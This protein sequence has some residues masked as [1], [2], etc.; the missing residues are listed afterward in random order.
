MITELKLHKLYS[1]WQV[2]PLNCFD[3][4][5]LATIMTVI[6]LNQTHVLNF[7][8]V[9]T[10]SHRVVEVQGH[11]SVYEGSVARGIHVRRKRVALLLATVVRVASFRNN[12]KLF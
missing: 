5:F 6:F 2:E 8:Q 10:F 12:Q 11:Q 9:E 3:G 7:Q 1:I 4:R